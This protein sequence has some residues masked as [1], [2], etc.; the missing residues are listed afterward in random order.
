MISLMRDALLRVSEAAAAQVG[1]LNRG[2]RRN[3]T[4]DYQALQN[5]Y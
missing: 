3:G 1:G 5:R 2:R 4:P